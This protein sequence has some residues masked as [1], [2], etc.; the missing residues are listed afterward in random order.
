[1]ASYR[2][3]LTSGGA[4]KLRIEFKRFDQS[5]DGL[6]QFQLADRLSRSL[7]H[8]LIVVFQCAD[9]VRRLLDFAGRQTAVLL[10]SEIKHEHYCWQSVVESHLLS[11]RFRPV[12]LAIAIRFRVNV[13]VHLNRELI[14][15]KV[16]RFGLVRCA[17]AN[18]ERR[19]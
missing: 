17:Q 18:S 13:P 7:S 14:A 1:M 10:P 12:S 6:F 11:W 2:S 15:K 3:E 19:R 4:T 16:S 8:N 9:E 5:G